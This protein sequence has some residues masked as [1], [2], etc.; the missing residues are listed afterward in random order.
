MCGPGFY[1]N[2][3]MNYCQVSIAGFYAPTTQVTTPVAVDTGYYA[4]IGMTYQTRVFPNKNLKTS[5]GRHTYACEP[6]Q[7]LINYVCTDAEAGYFAPIAYS[8]SG[9]RTAGLACPDGT[10][11][12][13]GSIECHVCP[14]GYDCTDKTVIPST[15]CDVGDYQIG[16]N[17]GCTACPDAHEC[18]QGETMAPCPVW[19]Y[20]LSGIT[21][22][23]CL[24]CPD[25]YNCITGLP[26]A[27]LAGT[28][29]SAQDFECLQCPP[30][31]SCGAAVGYPTPCPGGF[32]SLGSAET[33]EPCPTDYYAEEGNAYCS[34]VPPGHR[35]NDNS[36]GITVCPHKTMSDWGDTICSDCPDGYLCPEKTQ[37]N[38]AELACP[39]GSYCEKGV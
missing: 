36:D 25:G 19:H 27:C 8:T 6:G 5:D 26:V 29:S 18:N 34:P 10:W 17:M 23:D 37:M 9:H 38:T 15:R 1:S 7:I 39:R 4:E 13:A 20:A 32:Y 3:E 30:G 24:P 33:C 35:I 22:G 28:Y 21:S 16:G 14:P 31:Y 12:L 2:T 11:S